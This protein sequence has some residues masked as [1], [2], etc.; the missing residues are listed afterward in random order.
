MKN[1]FAKLFGVNR[2]DEV[3]VTQIAEVRA[4]DT[5]QELSLSRLRPNRY[6][7]RKVF[8]PAKIE[9]L[10]TTISEHGLLQPIV[11]R[12]ADGD[13]YEIIAGERRFRAVKS[14]G[15]SAIPAIVRDMD[16]DTTAALALIE[17]LQREQLSPIEEAEA[18]D[19]L[20]ALNGLTQDA[21]AKSLGK[22]QSTIANKLRLLKLPEDVKQ[23]LRDR[24]I[25]ERHARA[26]LP[27]KEE[28]LQLQVLAE[29]LE[30]DF[31]VKETEERV[32][33]L[34]TPIE[35][36]KR[37][38]KKQRRRTKS[39]ARDTRIAINTIRDSIDLIGKTGIDVQTEEVDEEE[40][41]EI[42]IRIPKARPQK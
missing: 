13:C 8:E 22:S 12:K 33:F 11:V 16:D 20:L 4:D 38:P 42:R 2:K 40:F 39:F 6:Q 27:L 36:E 28:G 7:P 35:E 18:Y 29:V 15:W 3:A 31:N 9:E 34:T 10:A 30:Q 1:R 21:L 17:N 25:N 37:K 5:V 19:R 26:L 24:R 23:S 32:A 41:V 14:L